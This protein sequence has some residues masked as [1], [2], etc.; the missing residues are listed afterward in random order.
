MSSFLFFWYLQLAAARLNAVSSFLPQPAISQKETP[1]SIFV[2]PARLPSAFLT[3][4]QVERT[5]REESK[6]TWNLKHQEEE[7]R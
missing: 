3:L 7:S 5:I 2:H 1:N 4:P 6:I